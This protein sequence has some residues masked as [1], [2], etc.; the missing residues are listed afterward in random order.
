VSASKSALLLHCCTRALAR[1]LRSAVP[2][3]GR[4][5]RSAPGR[6]SHPARSRS[7]GTERDAVSAS[8]QSHLMALGGDRINDAGP[9]QGGLPTPGS[10][11]ANRGSWR[12]PRA[13]RTPGGTSFTDGSDNGR[14]APP[15]VTRHRCRRSLRPRP[16]PHPATRRARCA[17]A[18]RS[19]APRERHGSLLA[20]PDRHHGGTPDF[21]LRAV[22]LRRI[23]GRWP[24]AAFGRHSLRSRG[25]RMG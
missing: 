8:V 9:C 23:P 3:G 15:P 24:S 7:A 4:A 22:R 12:S 21:M 11:P 13:A 19:L 6:A 2:D 10:G 14:P 25:P 1:G 16:E 18:S 20:P 17:A 5:V